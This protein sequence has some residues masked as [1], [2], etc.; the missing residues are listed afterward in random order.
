[1]LFCLWLFFLLEISFSY[2]ARDSLRLCISFRIRKTETFM[3][4]C[5]R[6]LPF[7]VLIPLCVL[8]SAL[9][10][11]SSCLNYSYI[12]SSFFSL[13]LFGPLHTV[14]MKIFLAAILKPSFHDEEM[15]C[16]WLSMAQC[17]LR[18]WITINSIGKYIKQSSIR[19]SITSP[20]DIRTQ[21][22][23]FSILSSL[24]ALLLKQYTLFIIITDNIETAQCYCMKDLL[25]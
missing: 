12:H 25:H 17:G 7:S 3:W 24:G 5:R 6:S 16:I 18:R 10:L 9:P 11:S 20:E 15:F 19:D 21:W 23:A 14:L 1:M 13:F 4:F 22:F 8:E 2:C